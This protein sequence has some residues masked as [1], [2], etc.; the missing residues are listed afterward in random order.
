[1]TPLQIAHA[2]CANYVDGKCLGFQITDDL[3][4]VAGKPL[5]KCILVTPGI[6]CTYF[7]QCVAPMHIE[8]PKRRSEFEQALHQYRRAANV[9][10]GPTSRCEGC[11]NIVEGH[12]RFCPKCALSRQQSRQREYARNRRLVASTNAP[13]K[14]SGK[15]VFLEAV[16]SGRYDDSGHV[17]NGA[18]NSPQSDI[19]RV[20]A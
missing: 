7:E 20:A 19:G 4:T 14:L 10:S 16:S 13:L 3:R 6:R 5:P 9:P 1:M 2:E 12:K 15:Q 11:H 8:D 17:Q 18:R